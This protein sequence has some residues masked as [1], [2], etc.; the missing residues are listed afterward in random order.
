VTPI[1]TNNNGVNFKRRLPELDGVRGCAIALVLVW[2]YIQN[3]IHAE[4]GSLSAYLKQAIGF[5]WSGVDLFFVLSGF[6]IAGILLDNRDKPHYFKA[7]YMRRA[8]RILPLYYL[9]LGLFFLFMTLEF[10]LVSPMRSLFEDNTVPLW[11]YLTFTQNISMAAQNSGGA[12]WLA[13]TWSLAVEEQFYLLFP[14]LVRYV[15]LRRLPLLFIWFAGMAVYLRFSLP[16]L[17]AYINTPWRADSLMIGALLAYLVRVPGFF[18]NAR[19]YRFAIGAVFVTAAM[20]LG[21]ANMNGGL[22]LGG[23]LTHLLLAVTF[24]LFLLLALLNREGVLGSV[25]RNRV[26][27]WLGSISY[28]VY[29]LHT[30]VSHLVHKLVRDARPSIDSWGGVATTLLAL[31]VTLLVAQISYQWFE[32][33]FIRYGHTVSYEK[34]S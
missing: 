28:G 3:Q 23:A 32:R 8:C 27:M 9:N 24:A 19:S 11:S 18:D 6:L 34:S 29:I 2:H 16:G 33:R 20:V 7:F 22:S 15:P 13:V 30:G 14:L 1:K 5:T 17:S 21:F 10:D 26:L 25:L 31:A 12:N 4:T